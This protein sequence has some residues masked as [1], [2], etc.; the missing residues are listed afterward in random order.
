[1]PCPCYRSR[2]STCQ[3]TRCLADSP[4]G[5]RRS[6]AGR[7]PE[8]AG[9]GGCRG[10]R[11][12]GSSRHPR[13]HQNRGGCWLGGG[14]HAF[15]PRGAL[16]FDWLGTPGWKSPWGG[17]GGGSTH[18]AAVPSTAAI[19]G[20]ACQLSCKAHACSTSQKTGI[21]LLRPAPPGSA[22]HPQHE[23]RAG[24]A[25]GRGGQESCASIFSAAATWRQGAPGSGSCCSCGHQHQTGRPR[26]EL[27][28]TVHPAGCTATQGSGGTLCEC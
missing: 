6:A 21:L 5:G 18:K 4:A 2:C 20:W 19:S 14:A 27:S 1:M 16:R 7:A 11:C 17:A 12:C 15:R 25:D 10:T 13:S 22:A 26:S 8:P 3:P 9:A 24:Q 23:E 28:S